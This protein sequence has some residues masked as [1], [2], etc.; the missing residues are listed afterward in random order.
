MNIGKINKMQVVAYEGGDLRVADKENEQET[1]LIPADSVKGTPEVGEEV[2]V[3]IYKDK[4]RNNV[5]TMFIPF[6]V[7]GEFDFME[8]KKLIKGGA[9]LDWGIEKD[10]FL[11]SRELTARVREGRNYLVY[12]HYDTETEQIIASMRVDEFMSDVFPT[13][14]MNDEV[15]ILVTRETDLGYQVIVDDKYWGLVYHSEVFEHVERGMRTVGYIKNVREDG[16][17]D[18]ALQKQGYK[19]VDELCERVV[20]ALDNHGGFLPYTD[21]TDSDVIYNE[22]GCSKKSFKKTIGTLYRQRVIRIEEKG[23]R[24]LNNK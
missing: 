23:I 9:L 12:V 3:F 5:P 16:K 22:F 11:P 20:D 7:D 21:K 8:V 10:L 14:Q 13:Y 19:V 18:V 6:A 24:L 2:S 17:I 15:E 4:E 1:L